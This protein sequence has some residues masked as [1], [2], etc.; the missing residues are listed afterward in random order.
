MWQQS[1]V[2]TNWN[3]F[4][5]EQNACVFFVLGRSYKSWCTPARAVLIVPFI[6]P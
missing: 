6:A 3:D 5:V 2:P 1:P 4:W